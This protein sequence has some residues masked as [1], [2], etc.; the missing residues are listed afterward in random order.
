MSTAA[1]SVR[2]QC[3][4]WGLSTAVDLQVRTQGNLKSVTANALTI[5]P[6]NGQRVNE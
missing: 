4:A 3:R 6:G 5:G 2:L 1:V